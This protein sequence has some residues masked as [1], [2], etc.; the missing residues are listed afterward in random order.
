MLVESQ[1]PH[2]RDQEGRGNNQQ[3]GGRD[4]SRFMASACR[5]TNEL[6]NTEDAGGSDRFGPVMKSF[7]KDAQAAFFARGTSGWWSC[8]TKYKELL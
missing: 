8:Q 1:P 4:V 5:I 2:L 3:V 6:K 7:I